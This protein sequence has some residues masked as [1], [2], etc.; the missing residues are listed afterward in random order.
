MADW[1]DVRR[2]AL[3]LPETTEVQS[4]GNTQW[5]VKDKLF[6]WERPLGK[7]DLQAL[8]EQAPEGPVLGVRVADLGDKLALIDEDPR[9]FFTIAHFEGYCAVLVHLEPIPVEQLKPVIIEAWLARAP[10]RLSAEYLG[11]PRG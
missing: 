9:F 7:A 10:A 1:D 4:R 6:V 2:I 11:Q 8:G 3:G 5:R